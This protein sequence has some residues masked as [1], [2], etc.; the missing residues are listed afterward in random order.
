MLTEM[1]QK[2]ILDMVQKKTTV[3]VQELAQT[4]GISESTVRRDLTQ[5]DDAGKLRKIYGGATVRDASLAPRDLSMGEKETLH[6]T[7][8]SC[9]AGYAA[10]LIQPDD[11]VYVDA[12][13]STLLLTEAADEA[14]AVYVT[15]SIRHA[16]ILSDKGFRTILLGGE[17]KR[18]TQAIVGSEALSSIAKYNFTAGFFGTNALD[19]THGFTTPDV[20]EAALKRE[21]MKRC[22][23]KYVL[24]DSSKFNKVSPVC[25]GNLQDAV[26]LT[27]CIPDARYRRFSNIRKVEQHDLHGNI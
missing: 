13:S 2:A 8:K 27:D 4:F 11:F 1:R 24:C 18:L 16:Q 7:E 14:G 20:T 5:L 21:A 17:I 9:I 26:V 6:Y 25:F 15:N 23:R 3:T 12:G 19:E 10:G 22:R